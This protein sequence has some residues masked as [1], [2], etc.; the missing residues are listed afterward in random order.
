[1]RYFDLSDFDCQETGENKMNKDFLIKLDSLRHECG[2]PFIVTSGYRSPEHSIEQRKAKAGT[3]SKGIAADIKADSAQAYIIQREA[4]K[5]GFAGIA[6]GKYFVHV[7]I[8]STTPKSW[9]Y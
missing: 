8:R 9:S 5:M 2:F 6:R 1:M 4:Y 7:D 3:H